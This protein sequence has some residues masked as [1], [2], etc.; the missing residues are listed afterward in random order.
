MVSGTDDWG[1]RGGLT[2]GQALKTRRRRCVWRVVVE[3]SGPGDSGCKGLGVEVI[4]AHLRM[5][6]R[7]VWLEGGGQEEGW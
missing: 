4:L 5:E 3:C 7:P 1:I 2:L 6:S